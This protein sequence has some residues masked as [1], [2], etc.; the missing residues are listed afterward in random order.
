MAMEDVMIDLET[1]GTTHDAA[2]V[3][4]GACY[5]NRLT[6]ETGST[7]EI[8]VSLTKELKKGFKVSGHTIEWWLQ[9]SEKARESIFSDTVTK[10]DS[11]TAFFGL[12]DFISDACYYWCHAIN[13]AHMI[14]HHFNVLQINS[15]MNFR[16]VRDIRTLVDLAGDVE[17]PEPDEAFVAHTALSD[18]FHQIKYCCACFKQLQ[19]GK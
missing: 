11:T 10:F 1:M 7:F 14:E 6:G 17:F 3:Q 8:N 15:N 18:C 5:F 16:G 12:N 13:D 9:Q 19:G 2:V 4:I